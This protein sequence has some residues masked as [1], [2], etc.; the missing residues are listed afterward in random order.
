HEVQV[1]RAADSFQKVELLHRIARLFED[2]VGDHAS[3]FDTYARALPLDDGNE[4][5]LGNLE[6]LAMAVN[7]WPEVSKLYD[8]QLDKLDGGENKDRFVELGLRNAQIFEVQ[9]EDVDGAIARYQRVVDS[10]PENLT[11]IRALD[12]LYAHT[13]R[14]AELAA[15]LGR[16]AEIGQSPDEV[17]EL[18]YRL[19]QVEQ[20]RLGN[21]DAAIA[22]YRD[23]IN[24]APEHQATLEAL[25]AL[26]ASGAKQAEVGEILEPLYR[27]MSEWEKLSTVYEAQLAHTKGQ[28]DRLA[29]YY[30]LAELFEEKLLD[31]ANT[32]AVYIRALKEF[33]L[34]EKAGEESP[35]LAGGVDG[36]WETLANAYAD[37][38]GAHAD[39]GVQ[40]SIGRRLART[41]EDELGDI[42]KAEETYKYVLSVDEGDVEALANLDRIYLSLESW[43]DLAQI[44]EMRVKATTDSIELVELYARLGELY[45]TRLVDL[46]NA[47]RAYR[48]IFDELDKTHEGAIAA[49]ARIYEHQGAWKE[50]DAVYQRELENAAGDTAEAEIRAKIAHIA[51]DKLGQPERAIETWKAVLDLRGE[52]PEAL[53]ALSNLY[54]SLGQW[55]K[56]VDILE[57]EFDI[58]STDEDRVNILT[59]RARTTSDKLGRDD[60]ALPDWNRVLDIDYANLAGLRAIADIRRRQ[61]D[62]NELVTALHQLVDRAA[63]LL[64]GEE[65]KEIFR[66]LG[67]T[68]GEALA[69]PY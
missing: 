42:G 32:L 67:K 24:A 55:A 54:D 69:Q 14:W 13:E 64:D 53:H 34:D 40:R 19:G 63:S 6:R 11:A 47:I 30:R 58:A 52:D 43:Q 37:V 48:H 59:R 20:T 15:I 25:E 68:Y 5:T 51:A 26:F 41:F 36:G 60:S 31:P 2:A 38:L 28:D 29:A 7:R 27:S 10:D 65:L 1:R 8:A 18:K 50:L 45:E 61:G 35:R 66:E 17:L 49:L 9:L 3:A 21:L 57:R 44:L 22:A 12:R 62:S 39:P 16:E 33:P 46:T 23:V 56:L 4:Q